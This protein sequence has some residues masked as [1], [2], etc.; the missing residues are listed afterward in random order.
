MESYAAVGGAHMLPGRRGIQIRNARTGIDAGGAASR[1]KAGDE[2]DG[3]QN[4]QGY[5]ERDWIARNRFYD[6]RSQLGQTRLVKPVELS[7][8]LRGSK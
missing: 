8:P 6:Q 1:E 7:I 5:A 3:N 4:N 2:G